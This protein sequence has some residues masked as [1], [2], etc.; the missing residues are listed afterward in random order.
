MHAAFIYR[1]Q[2][3]TTTSPEKW[4]QEVHSVHEIETIS[5]FFNIGNSSGGECTTRTGQT[6]LTKEQEKLIMPLVRSE[7]GATHELMQLTGGAVPLPADWSSER[8][9]ALQ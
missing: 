3:K 7:I 9:M 8:Q 4:W 6:T 5:E 2:R 1:E